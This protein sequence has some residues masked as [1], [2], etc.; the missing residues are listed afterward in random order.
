VG[1]DTVT[2]EISN[3]GNQLVTISDVGVNWSG[4][5]LLVKIKMPP[6]NIWTGAAA[7]PS[8]STGTDRKINPGQSKSLEF[9]FDAPVSGSASTSVSGGC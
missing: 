4:P 2:V 6:G 7:G 1:G 3:N 5:E 8:F 9:I